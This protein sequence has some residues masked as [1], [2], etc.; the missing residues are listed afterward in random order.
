MAALERLIET[1]LETAP[2]GQWLSHF[3]QLYEPVFSRTIAL[4]A[5]FGSC[6]VFIPPTLD[7]NIR[8]ICAE[9]GYIH[10]CGPSIYLRKLYK[11]RRNEFFNIL[12]GYLRSNQQN[13][14]KILF[15][16]YAHEDFTEFDREF[17]DELRYG[18]DDVK[19]LI[20]KFYMGRESLVWVLKALREK[21]GNRLVIPPPGDFRVAHREYRLDASVDKSRT[22]W[23]IIDHSIGATQRE[24]GDIAYCICYD[25]KFLNENPFHIFDENKPAWIDHTTMPHTLAGAMINI[26]RPEIPRGRSIVL[27]DPFSGTGT[28]LLECLKV[29]GISAIGSDLDPMTTLIFNDN[30]EFFASPKEVLEKYVKRLSDLISDTEKLLAPAALATHPG[31]AMQ[32]YQWAVQ[33]ADRVLKKS[34]TRSVEGLL[35][36]RF[37]QRDVET[38]QRYS[39]LDR[40]VFYLVLRTLRRHIPGFDRHSKEWGMAFR[41]EAHAL[42]SQV[43]KLRSLRERSSMDPFS[44]EPLLEFQGQ[45]SRAVSVHEA[46]LRETAQRREL[47]SVKVQDIR[48]L[49]PD[50]CDLIITDPPYGFNT[51][52]GVIK[53]AELYSDA[54]RIMILA[55]KNNGQLVFA[56]PD[57]SHT[58]RQL[59][60]FTF[61]EFITQQI[62]ATAADLGRVVVN[63]AY[64]VPPPSQLFR[65]PFYWES[66]RALRRAIL[67][68]KI[69]NDISTFPTVN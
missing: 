26:A 52:G 10:S 30:L 50:S 64:T 5:F 9:S 56:V 44:A 7:I 60:S 68:F 36:I 3:V 40:L 35:M 67:H 19:V 28:T 34:S 21:F 13:G 41:K 63:P 66:D 54:M 39:A 6:A 62:L 51:A 65:A 25:Q 17:A 2:L 46:W 1:F 43:I 59:A 57:W 16:V 53:L 42:L 20:E 29:K 4:D 31:D 55:L 58:G 8:A 47:I 38:L 14:K 12:D 11:A 15:T 18:L 48:D 49:K 32:A 27:A 22:I 61:R 37:S 23:L 69:R 45:Y 24:R 33:L